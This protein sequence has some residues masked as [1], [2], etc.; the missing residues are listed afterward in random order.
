MRILGTALLTLAG[1]LLIGLFLFYLTVPPVQHRGCPVN[2]IASQPG[3]IDFWTGE[4]TPMILTQYDGALQVQSV[5]VIP[6]DY[7][8]YRVIPLPV[9]FVVGSFLTLT[10]ITVATRRPR[11]PASDS[12]MPAA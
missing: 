6:E 11:R 12:A 4:I 1:G 8:D 9:G 10:V 7:R 5:T 3:H 2:C